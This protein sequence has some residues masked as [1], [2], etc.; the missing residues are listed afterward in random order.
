MY[1]VVEIEGEIEEYFGND[2]QDVIIKT[3]QVVSNILNTQNIVVACE[4]IK[5]NLVEISNNGK[6]IYPDKKYL[7]MW[8]R[9]LVF[10]VIYQYLLRDNTVYNQ[11]ELLMQMGL[12]TDI[13][14]RKHWNMYSPDMKVR[15]MKYCDIKLP[16]NHAEV[17]SNEIFRAMIHHMISYSTVL[18]DTFVDMFGKMGI[19]PALCANSKHG[20]KQ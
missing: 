9:K 12:Y 16:F 3:K 13:F 6:L 11:S 15:Q 19:V 17:E 14:R 7:P 18:T 10:M 2:N 1:S 8:I 5:N 4:M 20:G